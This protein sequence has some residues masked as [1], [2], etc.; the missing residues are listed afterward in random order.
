[1]NVKALPLS[2]FL[3]VRGCRYELVMTF[4]DP[5]SSGRVGAGDAALFLKRSG[6]T[7]LVLG[8]IWDLA[9]SDCKGLLNKQQFFVAL[10]L[11]A[12]AQNGL[13]VSLKS[14][15]TAVPPPKFKDPTVSSHPIILYQISEANVLI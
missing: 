14:L 5:S 15:N 1:V 11:V 3:S 7:D 10:R 2:V 13:E 9:D 4:V 12:C 8:K 6:L